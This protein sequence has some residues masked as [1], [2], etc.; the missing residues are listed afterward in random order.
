MATEG[1]VNGAAWGGVQGF[2]TFTHDNRNRFL[3]VFGLYVL[4]L[5]MIGGLV[6]MLPLLLFDPEHIILVDPV[7]YFVRYGLPVTAISAFLFWRLYTSHTE[8][9]CRKLAVREVTRIDE[10]RFVR[11]AEEQCIALGIRKPR[12]GLIEVSQPNAL[13]VGEGPQ[14]GLIA[15]TRGLLDQLD[16]D[17]LAAVLANL[18]SQIRNGDTSVLAANFAL[19]RT[20]VLM[21]VNNAFRI[22]DWR[23]LIIVVFLPPM[24]TILLLSGMI[25]KASLEIA[26]M[27]RRS[28]KLSRFHIADAEAIRVTH[29]PDALHSALVKI[30]GKGAF[31]G[32]AVFDDV[33]FDGRSDTDGGSHPAVIDRLKAIARLGG[34]MMQPG[35][36]RR[37]TRDGVAVPGAGGLADGR[38]GFGRRYTAA[39]FQPVAPAEEKP[40]EKPPVMENDALLVM[41]LTDW[42]GYKAYVAQCNDWFEWRTNDGRNL[43]GLKPELRLPVAAVTAGLLVLYWPADGNWQKL[44][45]RFNPVSMTTMFSQLDTGRTFCT[46]SSGK[47]EDCA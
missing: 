11:L 9:I 13:A 19:M 38:V 14:R 36:A 37:D 29:R 42:K 40:R 43:F 1:A 25:T 35:R 31:P 17:E 24:L 20:A 22:E 4:S 30:G 41:M 47:N 23:Q 32:S 10:R 15:V 5:H 27:A 44:A 33:L 28:V 46:P 7:G 39:H 3:Q 8:A 2:V 12:F 16:D 6:A 45:N 26:R 18:A 21:Q 34:P